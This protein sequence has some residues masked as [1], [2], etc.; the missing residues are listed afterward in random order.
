MHRDE[1]MAEQRAEE[2]EERD[3]AVGVFQRHGRPS[4]DQLKESHGGA[5]G[6]QRINR[7]NCYFGS[8]QTSQHSLIV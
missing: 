7:N 3:D 5:G 2:I 6:A 1:R 4:R 8:R